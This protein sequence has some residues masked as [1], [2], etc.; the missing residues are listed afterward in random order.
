MR[1]VHLDEVGSTNDVAYQLATRDE[2]LPLWVTAKRQTAG[3]GRRG[4][5]WTSDTGNLYCTGVYPALSTP[6]ETGRLSF[7]AALSVAYMLTSYVDP[8]MVSIK[9]PNDVLISGAKVSGILLEAREGVVLVGIGVNLMH[10]PKDTPYPATDVLSHI[11]PKDLNGPEPALPTIETCVASV[12]ARFDTLYHTLASGDFRTI[13]DLWRNQA[14]PLPC[15]VSVV[16]PQERFSGTALDLGENGE[17]QVELPDGT[18]RNVHAGDVF[19]ENRD[20]NAASD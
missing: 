15:P 18:I 7:V 6:Q 17:L 20:D 16:L 13:R 12:A 5:A 8:R 11:E 1:F 2:G 9:W 3:R 19:F 10:H 14:T 4:R